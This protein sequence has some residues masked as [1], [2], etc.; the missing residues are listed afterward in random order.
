M[1]RGI[2]GMSCVCVMVVR[3]C[4]GKKGEKDR[5]GHTSRL[6]RNPAVRHPVLE[7]AEPEPVNMEEDSMNLHRIRSLDLLFT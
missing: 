4:E 5:S 6:I 3:S 7:W 2:V 1:V